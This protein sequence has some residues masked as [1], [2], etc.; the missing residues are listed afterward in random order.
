MMKDHN[1]VLIKDIIY[2]DASLLEFT[3]YP[4]NGSII[5]FTRKVKDME[6]IL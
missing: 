1:H 4:E 2:E 6:Y 3:D 5:N